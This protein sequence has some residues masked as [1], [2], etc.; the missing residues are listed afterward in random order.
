MAPRTGNNLTE[1]KNEFLW[2][3]LLN[4]I[5]IFLITPNNILKMKQENNGSEEKDTITLF[6][7]L[8]ESDDA[9]SVPNNSRL[10]QCN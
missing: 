7:T 5:Q 6:M 1:I 10:R 9:V 4:G 3:K 2:L 8:K